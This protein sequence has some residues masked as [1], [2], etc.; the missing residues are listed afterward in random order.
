MTLEDQIYN[1]IKENNGKF[2]LVD[3]ACK[4]PGLTADI[5]TLVVY[6]LEE[7]GRVERR[8]VWGTRYAYFVRE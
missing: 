4:F 7:A 8:G 5:P 6:G 1:F 3:I 2:D